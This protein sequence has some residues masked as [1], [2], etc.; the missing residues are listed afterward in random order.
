MRKILYKLRLLFTGVYSE[1]LRS[2]ST[3]VVE[4]YHE[5]F[6]KYRK[7][8]ITR[9][10]G[11]KSQQLIYRHYMN[12]SGSF[13]GLNTEIIEPPFMPHG[14][15]GV[16]IA[17]GAKIGKNLTIYQHVTIGGNQLKGSKN[18]GCPTIEDGVLIGAGA[19][20]IG[21][22]T[23][24]QNSRVGAGCVVT[25]DVPPNSTV[26][27]SKPI[28]IEGGGKLYNEFVSRKDPILKV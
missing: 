1:F 3:L 12:K 6:W 2:I 25:I 26:V 17:E 5:G 11:T 28:I 16:F 24:G 21:N 4:R 8:L 14:L 10:G 19:K 27:M 18:F 22:I 9:N 15:N 20:I 13:V 7:H 23:V